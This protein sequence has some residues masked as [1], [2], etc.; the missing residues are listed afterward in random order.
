[1]RRSQICLG[2]NQFVRLDTLTSLGGFP[3]SGATEDST[4]GYALGG[5]G[6]LIP[7]PPLVELTDPPQTSEKGIPQNAPRDLGGLDDLPFLWRTWRAAPSAFNL[8]QLVRHVGNKVVEWPVAAL[9]YPA[10]GYLGWYLAYTY[11]WW[12]PRLFY[13]AIGAPT[14]SLLLTIWVG[15]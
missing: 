8:A 1:F 11:R 15:G 5:G 12:S 13:V 3:T 2:H 6:L 7:A 9:V 14:L 10:L 4:L